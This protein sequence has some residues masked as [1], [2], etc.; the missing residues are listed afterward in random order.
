MAIDATIAIR[1][2]D[3]EY[4]LQIVAELDL[5]LRRVPRK[6]REIDTTL[7]P[8]AETEPCLHLF[9]WQHDGW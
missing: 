6:Q 1:G 7:R 4:D 2:H 9:T 5:S 3:D 8:R